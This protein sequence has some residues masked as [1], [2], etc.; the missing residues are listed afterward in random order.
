MEK[1]DLRNKAIEVLDEKHG[2][3]VRDFFI[4]NGVDVSDFG[5][6][7][8]KLTNDDARYYFVQNNFKVNNASLNSILSW[9]IELMELPEVKKSEDFDFA[10]NPND[11]PFIAPELEKDYT[12]TAK[13]F[14]QVI[15]Q[16]I[17]QLTETLLVKG[18][19]YRR[20]GNP[21]T[22]LKWVLEKRIKQG[23][24]YY[25]GLLLNTK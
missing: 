17:T 21:F 15:E 2:Q 20:N 4:K 23:K 25:M 13:F 11:L 10:I 3:L 5:F 19:E 18:K 12:E 22:T 9:R 7:N 6:N 1:L 24:K 14:D 16:T 8:T